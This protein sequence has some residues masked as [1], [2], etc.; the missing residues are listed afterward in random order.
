M[1]NRNKLPY[2][3]HRNAP[4]QPE[5][6]P[7]TADAPCPCCGCVTIPNG[8]DAIAYICPVCLW[9]IDPFIQSADEPSDQNHG[10]TLNQCREN[11]RTWGAVL[12]R[13]TQ[14]A[15]PPLPSE[16]PDK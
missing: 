1:K 16:L 11:Y 13:L 9:E 7:V 6:T 12:P 2:L 8:G 4:P 14:Y 15:R 3:P 10:L 5:A